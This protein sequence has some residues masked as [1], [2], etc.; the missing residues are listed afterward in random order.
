MANPV[1]ICSGNGRYIWYYP[2]TGLFSHALPSDPLDPWPSL[3]GGVG[4]PSACLGGTEG[5]QL[6]LTN[7]SVRQWNEATERYDIDRGS[8][9]AVNGFRG[10]RAKP[11]GFNGLDVAVAASV[12]GKIK[13]FL[14]DGSVLD[15]STGISG[16]SSD[17]WGNFIGDDG[18]VVV[19]TY[20][21]NPHPITARDPNTGL[22]STSVVPAPIFKDP[23]GS[24]AISEGAALI[25]VFGIDRIFAQ[26]YRHFSWGWWDG[27]SWSI[28]NGQAWFAIHHRHVAGDPDQEEAYTF[29]NNIFGSGGCHVIKHSP[30]TG[31]VVLNGVAVPA[32]GNDLEM[33]Y[34]DP[35]TFYLSATAGGSDPNGAFY[36]YDFLNDVLTEIDVKDFMASTK[37][38]GI[39]TTP[40]NVIVIDDVSPRQLSQE[41]GDK[42]TISLSGVVSD[43]PIRVF[44]DGE[45]C[46]GGRGYGYDPHVVGGVVEAYAPKLTS[47]GTVKLT[48]AQGDVASDEADIDILER[49][50]R[51]KQFSIRQAFPAWYGAGPRRLDLEDPL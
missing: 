36:G 39:W 11:D 51:N 16:A 18:W 40:T 8:S 43:G 46:Y 31:S 32:A 30:S 4:Y 28:Y 27:N 24:N 21:G 22:W 2:D 23:S 9:L 41:G 48:L 44:I 20:F 49:P 14:S 45:P 25:H 35:S 5:H 7:T 29:G 38:V 15:E 3:I 13:L 47:K 10:A 12:A 19:P 33:G 17:A 42:V 26:S 34:V 1:Y 37:L 6:A 50:W